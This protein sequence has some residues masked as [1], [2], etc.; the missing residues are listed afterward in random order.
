MA[1][2]T[3]SKVRGWEGVPIRDTTCASEDRA[4]R[5]SGSGV[6]TVPG[7]GG[8]GTTVQIHRA[9]PRGSEGEA[10]VEVLNVR[11][12]H[13]ASSGRP[14]VRPKARSQG[15]GPVGSGLAGPNL[16]SGPQ[17][18]PLSQPE[19]LGPA[20]DPETSVGPRGSR[21]G[22]SSVAGPAASLL[23]ERV[24][25]PVLHTPS[26]DVPKQASSHTCRYSG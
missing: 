15:T 6:G 17:F 10:R 26:R 21:S 7:L 24:P 19:G 3:G 1:Q 11:P 12:T 23:P 25:A 13:V 20:S 4:P 16:H 2:D 14:E 22:G 5:G 18:R 9:D 8:Q